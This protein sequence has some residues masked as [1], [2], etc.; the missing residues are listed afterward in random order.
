MGVGVYHSDFNG[1]GHTFLVSG[2]LPTEADHEAYIK[3]SDLEP[4][5]A[6]DFP[7]W[8]QDQY[9]QAN[10]E[11]VVAVE[12]ACRELGF[13]IEDRRGFRASRAAFDSEF[14]AIGHGGIVDL[15]WRAW[16][17]DFVVA[18]GPSRSAEER[19]AYEADHAVREL[20]RDPAFYRQDYDAHTS[21]I[22]EFVRLSLMSNASLECRY[23][24]SGYTSA[25]YVAPENVSE[26]L[27]V[28]KEQVRRGADKLLADPADALSQIDVNERAKIVKTAIS[29]RMVV[30]FPVAEVKDGERR[31]HLHAVSDDYDDG[32]AVVASMT[33]PNELY[34]HFQGKD[35]GVTAIPRSPVTE[36]WFNAYQQSIRRADLVASADE[37]S[38]ALGEE[39]AIRVYDPAGN[40]AKTIVVATET[41]SVAGPTP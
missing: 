4:G 36:V 29:E 40:S 24:T 25:A 21:A 15:G 37:I 41:E 34:A 31:L 19:L 16:E 18:V 23:K 27:Q 7:T 39:V 26:R 30:V 10:E 22:E 13:S 35:D 33:V 17:T 28:L 38:K 12:Q 9:D 3:E 1:A 11:L 6:E 8:A 5:E 2:P 14:V 20:G 32:F